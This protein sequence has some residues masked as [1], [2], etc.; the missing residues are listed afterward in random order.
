M[1]GTPRNVLAIATALGVVVGPASCSDYWKI[2]PPT[3]AIY[4]GPYPDEVGACVVASIP[5]ARDDRYIGINFVGDGIHVDDSEESLTIT[6]TTTHRIADHPNASASWT[7]NI[8][9]GTGQAVIVEWSELSF[10]K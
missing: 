7:C 9:E 1:T 2:D 10:A 6:G 4:D 3:R 5:Y 8:G